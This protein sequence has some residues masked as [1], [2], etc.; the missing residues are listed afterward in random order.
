M[1]KALFVSFI[2]VSLPACNNLRPLP[3]VEPNGGSVEMPTQPDFKRGG[4][5]PATSILQA[6]N[7]LK[8]YT[9]S[10]YSTADNL[11]SSEFDNADLTLLGG[12][13][14]IVGGVAKSVEIAVSGGVLSAGASIASQRYQLKIQAANYEKAGDAMACMYR[15]GVQFRSIENKYLSDTPVFINEKIDDVRGKLRKA[16]ISVD[17]LSPKTDEL[18]AS[19]KKL[20]NAN[21]VVGSANLTYRNSLFSSQ[22]L[23]LYPGMPKIRVQE[24]ESTISLEE[25]KDSLN[26]A[27]VEKINAEITKCVASI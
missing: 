6:V 8:I 26:K 7:N 2:V 20:D 4:L 10:Y 19:L 27:K 13:A 15:N 21:V 18:T 1:K 11:R 5:I 3:I 25:A 22:R 17:L 9:D 14:A 24:V 16:Q 23:D 12:I